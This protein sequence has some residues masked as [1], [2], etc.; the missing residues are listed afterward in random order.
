MDGCWQ[1]PTL[2]NA[3]LDKLWTD[4][5]VRKQRRKAALLMDPSLCPR[6]EPKRV[7]SCSILRKPTASALQTEAVISTVSEEAAVPQDK[8]VALRCILI[9]SPEEFPGRGEGYSLVIEHL[10]TV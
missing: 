5:A 2:S 10:P 4:A 1:P 8:A 7:Y 9:S 3:Q 6:P